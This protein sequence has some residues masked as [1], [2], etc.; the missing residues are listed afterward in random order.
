MMVAPGVF[1]PRVTSGVKP[2][3]V[4]RWLM[5]LTIAFGDIGGSASSYMPDPVGE[6]QQVRPRHQ[7]LLDDLR[8]LVGVDRHRGLGEL[9]RDLLRLDQHAGRAGV[10]RRQDHRH[11]DRR[12]R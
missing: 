12:R 9:A 4:I 1:G 8:L 2:M 11:R 7:P 5:S 6:R 10:D 3:K